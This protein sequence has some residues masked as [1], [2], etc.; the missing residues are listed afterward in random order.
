MLTWVRARLGASICSAN[1]SGPP[2]TL[3]SE[4]RGDG[5]G[6]DTLMQASRTLCATSRH[7]L[8]YTHGVRTSTINPTVPNP[9][10]LAKTQAHTG[11]RAYVGGS[12]NPRLIQILTHRYY[13][14]WILASFPL[15]HL[16]L[17]CNPLPFTFPNVSCARFIMVSLHLYASTAGNIC[18]VL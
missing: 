8:G 15:V 18:R 17:R 5:W 9:P 13:L 1:S 10:L 11:K 12:V 4:R 16:C 6:G 7:P 2:I 14:S 3:I